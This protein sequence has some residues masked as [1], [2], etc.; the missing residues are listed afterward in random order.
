VK[1]V[2]RTATVRDSERN[3]VSTRGAAIIVIEFEEDKRLVTTAPGREEMYE[4]TLISPNTLETDELIR[5]ET[6]P[7][8]VPKDAVFRVLTVS[9][10]RIGRNMYTLT[11]KLDDAD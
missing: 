5:V 8:A 7:G 4:A 9:E 1:R 3:L 10:S 11:R 2:Y 6:E